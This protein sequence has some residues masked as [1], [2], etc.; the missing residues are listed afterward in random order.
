MGYSGWTMEL[1]RVLKSTTKELANILFLS[2]L[3]ALNFIFPS[4]LLLI[5]VT[6]LGYE[7]NCI[8]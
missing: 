4:S 6:K 8:F 5:Y 3:H 7:L 2:F 1:M